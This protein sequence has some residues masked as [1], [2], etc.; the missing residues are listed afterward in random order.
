LNNVDFQQSNNFLNLAPGNYTAYVKDSKGCIGSKEVTVTRSALLNISVSKK[1]T[2]ICVNDGSVN[3][4]ASGGTTPYTYRLN[5]GAY[6]VSNTFSALAVGNYSLTVK[7]FKGC[8]KTV[9]VNIGLNEIVVNANTTNASNCTATDGSIQLSAAGGFGPYLYSIDGSVFQTGNIFNNLQAGE[10][11]GYAKDTKGCLGVLAV[12]P[13]GPTNC[14][15]KISTVTKN[16]NG[17]VGTSPLNNKIVSLNVKAFPNPSEKEFTLFLNGYSNNEKVLITVTDML[18]RKIYQTS[19]TGKQQFKFG[20]GFM[21]GMYFVEVAQGAE[22][23][24][25][26]LIKE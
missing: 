5:G 26:K 25:L 9:G 20:S 6:Q 12:I 18:G 13:V 17:Q 3:I 7:D 19:G 16:K 15:T 8:T 14:F 2:S 1:N 11:S 23:K 4:S 21:S 10:Y 24:S 22:K